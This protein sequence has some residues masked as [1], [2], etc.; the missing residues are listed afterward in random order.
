MS[1]ETN[2]EKLNKYIK[3]YVKNIDK[4]DTDEL[5]VVFG[6]R[7][8][9]ITRID[10]EN[11]ISKLKSLGFVSVNTSGSYHLNI[12]NQYIDQRTGRTNISNIRTTVE[13]LKD[14]QDY[15]KS[16]TVV[17]STTNK[18]LH[19]VKFVQK[20]KKID[21][22][23]RYDP[24][25]Y[26][27][28]GFRIN[29]KEEKELKP[30]FGIVRD[31]L[32]TWNEKKKIFRLLKRFT[33]TH[34]K[35]PVN[36]DLSVV[37]SS[38]MSRGRMIPE[39]RIES[40]NL[41]KNPEIYEI[42]IEVDKIR[43]PKLFLAKEEEVN[44]AINAITASIRQTTKFVLSGLQE[45]NYPISYNEVDDILDEY[46]HILY[47]HPPEGRIRSRNFV[48][49]SSISLE[50]NN[51]IPL[52]KDIKTP[53]IRNPYTITEKA[54]GLRKLLFIN[55]QGKVYLI[56]TNMKVQFTGIKTQKKIYFNS[57]L[58]GEHVLHD[59]K[60]KFINNYLAF[61]IY[62]INKQDIRSRSFYKQ[63]EEGIVG[64]LVE[65]NRLINNIDFEPFIGDMIPLK[66][67]AK[68]FHYSDSETDNIFENCRTILERV[69]DGQYEYETDGLIFTPADT[70]VGSTRAGEILEPVKKTWKL[71][72]K[73]KPPEQNTIDFLVTTIKN[74]SNHDTIKNIFESGKDVRSVNNM[75]EYKTL[76]L[77]VGYSSRDGYLN[78]VEDVL[79]DNIP[80]L[81]ID[82]DRRDYKP[83]P[84]YPTNPTPP[85]P[86]YLCNLMLEKVGSQNV[87]TTENK[88]EIIEDEMIVEFKYDN[89]RD[90]FWQW[91]PIKVRYD[92]TADYKNGG[93][94]YGNSFNTAQ[95]VWN[96]IHYPVTKEMIT[97][98]KEIPDVLSESD[99]YYVKSDNTESFTKN[100]RDFHNLYVKRKLIVGVSKRNDTL[101]DMSVG[102]AGDFPKWIAAKLSFV[103]GIDLARDNIENR[104]NGAYARYLN[105]RR[106]RKNMPRALFINGNSGLNIKSGE[107]SV[108]EKGREITRA[109]FGDGPKDEERLGKGVFKQYGVGSE[110]FDVVSNQF[111]LHYFFEDL[112]ILNNFLRNVSECCKTGGY[113]IGCCYDGKS[114]FRMLEEKAMGEGITITSD[115]GKKIWEI[116]KQYDA[117]TLNND[118]TSVGHKIGVYQESINK[119]IPE[120]LVNFDYLTRILENYGFIPLEREEA[121]QMDLPSAN[122]SFED[123]FYKMN[124]ELKSK[125][126]YYKNIGNANKLSANERRIS[127]LNKYF[128][129]KKVRD[130]NAEA[131]SRTLKEAIPQQELKE[132]EILI[133]PPELKKPK[134]KKKGKIKI[135]AKVKTDEKLNLPEMTSQTKELSEEKG[136]E[137]SAIEE[138]TTAL[139]PGE[140]QKPVK[141]KK[142]KL[143]LK[144]KKPKVTVKVKDDKDKDD[145]D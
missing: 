76:Q 42:E 35:F 118:F 142:P 24:I 1:E 75:K 49:P 140:E 144:I 98:G 72:F 15:C 29:Y 38:S 19:N 129:Y 47:K 95:S 17:D 107:A 69:D 66:V 20:K 10:F 59:K 74:E 43:L 33:Y 130:V 52:E 135:K 65:L 3:A 125:K 124:S 70:G 79:R 61:D 80:K 2:A 68:D 8:H 39:F 22:G 104:L 5:E 101:I 123:L 99:V 126:L 116:K 4:E 58:D 81:S 121:E 25:D 96:S 143:K 117:K 28:F 44:S 55:R 119:Y 45:S 86:A 30:G 64:R 51:I 114:V 109:I 131:V 27:N 83:V 67:K 111:S 54:D 100:L 23:E 127:F 91:I 77:R 138:V 128:I 9:K 31:L 122:G 94:N 6:N 41:F 21:G 134:L 7:Q 62:Y 73:W 106:E 102:K 90:K 110:G 16:N 87:M 78:P 84:F 14:I 141:I 57:I 46:I 12:Q 136:V 36:I 93:R 139:A 105:Y 85:F 34:P 60:G 132:E 32:N 145:K 63:T 89:T 13:G 120:Y 56:D 40:S 11:V 37:R 97:T 88:E 133:K 53:N 108:T 115:K 26:E 103:F 71:S 50:L 112:N 82:E 48:G 92:K 113:F 137:K 18:A